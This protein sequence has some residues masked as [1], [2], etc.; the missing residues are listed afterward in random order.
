MSSR[1]QRNSRAANDWARKRTEAIAKAKAKRAALKSTLTED[2]TFQPKKISREP[3]RELLATSSD[4]RGHGGSGSRGP[5]PDLPSELEQLHARGDKKFG[6]PRGYVPPQQQQRQQQQQQQPPRQAHG[7]GGVYDR[8]GQDLYYD[9]V[10]GQ[11]PLTR[12]QDQA[13]EFGD[14]LDR[15]Y[16]TSQARIQQRN[17]KQRGG[18]GNQQRPNRLATD[19]VNRAALGQLM[20]DVL[21]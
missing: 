4:S 11:Q 14:E 20:Y 15:F 12:N 7:H 6:R 1:G 3:S 10:G 13:E 17:T 9:R 18:S 2:H 5:P 8:N 19:K 21:E 16:E